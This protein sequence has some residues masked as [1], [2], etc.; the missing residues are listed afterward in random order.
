MWQVR[1]AAPGNPATTTGDAIIGQKHLVDPHAHVQLVRFLALNAQFISLSYRHA[2]VIGGRQW[3]VH[4]SGPSPQKAD[5]LKFQ[6]PDSALV[7]LSNQSRVPTIAIEVGYSESIEDL[8]HDA[9]ILLNGGATVVIVVKFEYLD[10]AR[11]PG[12]SWLEVWKLNVNG[13]PYKS[14]SRVSALNSQL[15][16]TFTNTIARLC[17]Q[18]QTM[19]GR[20]QKR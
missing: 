9:L 7:S 11:L 13:R 10:A 18:N 17:S 12:P 8:H 19:L 6:S 15:I 3:H 4:I 1:A 2:L 16:L 5:G 14:V 20:M